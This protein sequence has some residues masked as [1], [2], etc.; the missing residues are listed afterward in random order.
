VKIKSIFSSAA[1]AREYPYVGA[2]ERLDPDD[3]LLVLFHKENAGIVIYAGPKSV[4]SVGVYMN[5]WEEKLFEVFEGSV[6]IQV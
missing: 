2:C 4:W 3:A 5:G 1:P 6:T